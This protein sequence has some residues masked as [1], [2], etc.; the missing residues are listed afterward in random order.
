MKNKKRILST[1]IFI[2]LILLA[3]AFV[4]KGYSISKF[5]ETLK[6]CKPIYLSLAVLCVCLWVFFEALFF[7]VIYKKLGYKISLFNAIGY[8]FTETYFSAITPSSTGGQPVQMI[9]M[10]KD[11][12]PY[13]TSSIVV[14]VNTM[15]YKLSLLLII[16]IGFMIYHNEIATFSPLFRAMSIYGFIITTIIVCFFLL[17]IFSEK[18]I[19]KI[20]KFLVSI[21]T[22][23]KKTDENIEKEDRINNV[24][25]DYK[26]AAKYIRNNPKVL[27]NTFL[28][29]FMQ[30]LSMLMVNYFVYKSFNIND[31]SALYA[32]T[33]NAFLMI[34][35]DFMP[36]PGGVLISEALL[37]EVNKKLHILSMSKG[38]TLVF[39]NISFYF[40]VIVSLIGYLIFHFGKRKKAIKIHE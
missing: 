6:N 37:L 15:F 19:N 27:L 10:S 33:I 8:V 2:L 14:L 25:C 21:I 7:K 26:E 11:E 29:I 28:I 31:I 40:L 22:R 1:V 4:F 36:L 5:I 24:L 16:I 35:V 18:T 30:R 32:I 20:L 13:R 17:L 9:E 34:S 39:R 12:I 38:I 3:Y 23:V